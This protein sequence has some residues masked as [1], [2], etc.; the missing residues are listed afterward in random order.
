MSSF[1]FVM[2]SSAGRYCRRRRRRRRSTSLRPTGWLALKNR[3][4]DKKLETGTKKIFF[5]RSHRE[6]RKTG[7]KF[8]QNLS[9]NL[10]TVVPCWVLSEKLF[11]IVWPQLFVSDQVQ[12]SHLK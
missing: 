5:F 10:I 7:R 4:W 1:S 6:G 8:R 12:K 11:I 9:E 3:W 2:V